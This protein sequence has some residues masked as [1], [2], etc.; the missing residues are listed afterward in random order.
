[1][2][3]RGSANVKFFPPQRDP[4]KAVAIFNQFSIFQFLINSTCLPCLPVGRAGR[5][6]IIKNLIKI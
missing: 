2:F 4:A 3:W 5:N 6:S 1:M